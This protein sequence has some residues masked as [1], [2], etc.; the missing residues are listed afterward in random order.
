M[1]NQVGIAPNICF[2]TV[3]YLTFLYLT[4]QQVKY[5]T[6]GWCFTVENT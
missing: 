6:Q 2:L 5:R 3:N 4:F 1:M